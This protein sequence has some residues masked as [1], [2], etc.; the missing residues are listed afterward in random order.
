MRF[1]F[2][3]YKKCQNCERPGRHEEIFKHRRPSSIHLATH[4][5]MTTLLVHVPHAVPKAGVKY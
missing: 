4:I 5:A 1:N 2:N 3:K